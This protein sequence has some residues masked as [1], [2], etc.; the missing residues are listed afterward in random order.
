[1]SNTPN[2]VADPNQPAEKPAPRTE[3][4]TGDAFATDTSELLMR[5]RCKLLTLNPWYGT[6]ASMFRWKPYDGIKTIGV[7]VVDG[8]YV[9]C[10]YNQDFCNQMSV[11]EMMAVVQ[12]EIEHIVRLHC[13]RVGAR[14]ARKWNHATDFTING[15]ESNPNIKGLPDKEDLKGI[16]Y[17]ENWDGNMTSE[18]LYDRLQKTRIRYKA[19]APGSAGAAGW[20]NKD[21]NGNPQDIVDGPS[22]ATEEIVIEGELDDHDIWAG[23]TVGEDEARQVVKDMVR[24]AGIKAGNVPGHL[25]DALAALEKPVVNWKYELRQYMGRAIGGR[26][27]TWA[28]A[29][30]RR[31]EFGIKGKSNKASVKLTVG[32]DTSGSVSKKLLEQFFSE[33]EMISQKFK[34]TLVQFDHGY[35]CHD[36]YHRGD[37][38]TLE[39]KGRG[40]TSFI[41]YFKAIEEKKLV[42][43]CNIVLTDGE[44]RHGEERRYPV[45]WVIMPHGSKESVTPPWGK[46]IFIE[47]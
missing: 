11:D 37:W 8:G 4:D 14:D 21:E 33:L 6:M 40:G 10:V 3:A 25:S 31:P 30:R 38:K 2:K 47:K 34:V 28:R 29:N 7:R 17:P 35:Q 44:A 16:Y 19:P 1:M 15:K 46:F 9:D 24:Q 26:R 18:E 22:D 45:L 43:K 12:H 13:V 41:E 20:P 27:S 23:S 36:A 32:V 39:V 42:G 5:A